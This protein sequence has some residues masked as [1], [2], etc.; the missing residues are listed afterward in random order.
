MS[1]KGTAKD[2][3]TC[4]ALN[5]AGCRASTR[6]A[7][8][9]ILNPGNS[10]Y[11]IDR[12][13]YYDELGGHQNAIADYDKFIEFNPDESIAYERQGLSYGKLGQHE[14]ASPNMTKRSAM[15]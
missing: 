15:I 7:F 5:N 2:P 1:P 14:T 3:G 8:S 4:S 9:F 13:D 10:R 6:E 11:Y 12:G